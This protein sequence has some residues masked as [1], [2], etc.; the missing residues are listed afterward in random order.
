MQCRFLDGTTLVANRERRG[1]EQRS[2]RHVLVS[3]LSLSPNRPTYR[4]SS[5]GQLDL[6]QL[7]PTSNLISQMMTELMPPTGFSCYFFLLSDLAQHNSGFC[8]FPGCNRQRNEANDVNVAAV[9]LLCRHCTGSRVSGGS[10]SWCQPHCTPE[11]HCKGDS[12]EATPQ[13]HPL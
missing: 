1:Q 11:V 3:F 8:L 12:K 9:I 4:W 6:N 10:R 5:T 2:C 13:Q 7:Q